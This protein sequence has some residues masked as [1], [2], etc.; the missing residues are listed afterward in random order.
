MKGGR[1][2]ELNRELATIQENLSRVME[3]WE[4]LSASLPTTDETMGSVE[5]AAV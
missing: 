5:S 1:A 4:R 3:E 2:F